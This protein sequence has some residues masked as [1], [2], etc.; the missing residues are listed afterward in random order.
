MPVDV[1]GRPS[2]GDGLTPGMEIFSVL[3]LDAVAEAGVLIT[4]FLFLKDIAPVSA[5]KNLKPWV[6][7]RRARFT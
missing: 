4:V 7:R 3:A 1:V 2:R 5:L 6:V